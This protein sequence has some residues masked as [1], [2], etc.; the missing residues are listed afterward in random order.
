MRRSFMPI[1]H[2]QRRSFL[3]LLGGAAASAWPLS[4][5]AQ[6]PTKRPLIGVLNANT[7][8]GNSVY[9]GYFLQRLKELGYN[10][11][12]DIDIVYR[13]A[14][15]DVGRLPL[16]AD[17]LVQLKPT[18]I[19]APVTASAI[20]AK[21]AT[22]TIPIVAAQLIDPVGLG[23]VASH[24]RPGGNV[25]GI[26]ASLESLPGKQIEL[27]REVVPSA[28]RIGILVNASNAQNLIQVRDTKSAT[29]KMPI[30]LISVEIQSAGELE[31]AFTTMAH[32]HIEAL[33]VLADSIFLGERR[34]IGAMAAAAR[35]PTI[36]PLRDHVEDGG[37]ISYAINRRDN[38][39]RAADYVD[40]ILKGAKA[41]DLPV[42]LPVRF[43]LVVNLKAAKA[44]GLTIPEIFLVRADEVIE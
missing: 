23:L 44:I 29:G 1:D 32:Q 3:A 42:E 19:M 35:L 25:T 39:R 5:R 40:K 16:L 9:I 10:E 7:Q 43:E 26:L 41:S 4:A 2:L 28:T 24:P 36:Y 11:G 17:E 6:T 8:Q 13:H 12:R 14:D 15:F 22:A 30:E 21:K 37:L 20:A 34:R 27:L 31:A 38:F 18:V 33:L